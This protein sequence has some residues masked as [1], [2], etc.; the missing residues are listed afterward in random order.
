MY[1]NI[2]DCGGGGMILKHLKKYWNEIKGSVNESINDLKS[3]KTFYKQIPNILTF[4]R[5]ILAIPV[6]L[7]FYINPAMSITLISILW[8]T[9][10]LDGRIARK[11]DLQS[12][13][14]ADMDTIADKLMFLGSA[15][16]LLAT[17][18]IIILNL[19]LE[20]V[21][22]GVNVYGRMKNVDTRTVKSGKV[23]TV[24]LA[25]MLVLSYL[26]QFVNIPIVILG[27]LIGFTT[28][29]QFVAIKD[30][31]VEFKKKSVELKQNIS[32][33]GNDVKD[34]D[35]SITKSM[36]IIEELKK[37]REFMLASK[38]P[39]KVYTGKKRVRLKLKEKNN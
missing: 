35:L 25:L 22:A 16:P 1:Y 4:M 39:D 8:L 30:Y 32:L 24:S 9:D 14:G 28:C 20:A 3:I 17:F 36:D 6:G 33:S 15:I 7:L 10:A 12:K 37:E 18:P 27:I 11:F 2:G 31:I 21:I 23:K 26:V 34:K 13:L 38:E 19:A 5:L 29:L